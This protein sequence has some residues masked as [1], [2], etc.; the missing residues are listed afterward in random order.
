MSNATDD[1]R[2]TQR[3]DDIETLFS[4]IATLDIEREVWE[5]ATIRGAH[6][7][8]DRKTAT[9]GMVECQKAI[10][11]IAARLLAETTPDERA[12]IHDWYGD[13]DEISYSYLAYATNPASFDGPRS[14]NV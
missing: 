4:T 12:F 3:T 9:N 13:D 11:G 5:V 14:G 1:P 8:T 6:D 10:A 7:I 2:R